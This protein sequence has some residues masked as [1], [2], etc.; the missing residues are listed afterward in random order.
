MT[1]RNFARLLMNMLVAISL[2]T[3][4]LSCGGGGDGDSG[5]TPGESGTI[6]L[7]ASETSIPADNSSSCIIT[8]TILDGS[9]NPVRHYT[10]VTFT[11][12]LG[13]FRNGSTT[14][15]VQT[16]PP[17]G[18]DG[19]P[20]PDASPTGV[21]E[22]QFIAGNTSGSAKITASSNGVTQTIYIALTHTGNTGVPVGEAFSLSAEYLNVSG[23]WV[24]SLAD[25]IT[26]SVGDASGTAV[27]DGTIID[28]KT[29]NTGGFFEM[30]QA[31]TE[32]GRALSTLYSAASPAPTEGFLMATGETTGG[33][34]TRVTSIAAVP[35]PDQHIMYAG[36]NGGGVYKST[37][38]GTTWETVSRSSEN[39]KRGQNLIEPYIKGHSGIAIDPD[40][41]N[42][43]YVGTGYLGKGNVYRS[44]DGGNNWNSNNT[45]EWN[46]IYDTT[47]AVLAV[48]ADGDD[49]ASTDY[50][51]VWIGTEGKGAL[52]ATDGKT[53]QPSGS[54]ASTPVLIGTGNGTMSE[55]VVSYTSVSEEW[56]A[57]Y[58]QTDGNA[59][60]PTFSG[61]GDGSISAISTSATTKTETW[62]VQYETK[63]TVGT[64][65]QGAGNVGD[66]NVVSVKQTEPNAASETWTLTAID[67]S[68]LIGPVSWDGVSKAVTGSAIAEGAVI[69]ISVVN[70]ST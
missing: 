42:N 69:G 8:A 27:K 56:T 66:G 51:Y 64:V 12:T 57:T 32:S 45:E 34:T 2:C 14:Y 28:F 7:S 60:T 63:I 18:S 36:T 21:V 9:G 5:S 25:L 33:S 40:N 37:D 44:L 55:P 65:T 52:Y 6:T 43:V 10:D 62:N 49:L 26:A 38:Y 41:H 30:D 3:F 1:I 16:Q 48:V 22:V 46:G 4:A 59:T 70:R 20:N 31:A 50:P 61:T 68:T 54:Y 29:Y 11:T 35:Y 67:G 53:F 13:R 17:L 15:K 39:P 19:F 47:A 23:W 24:S 58:V